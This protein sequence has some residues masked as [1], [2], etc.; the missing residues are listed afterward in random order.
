MFK[1]EAPTAY[2]YGYVIYWRDGFSEPAS[3]WIYPGTI[4]LND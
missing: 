2:Y 1:H 3:I 4:D